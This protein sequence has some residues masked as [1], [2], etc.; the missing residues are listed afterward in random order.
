MKKGLFGRKFIAMMLG[1]LLITAMFV[2]AAT[3]SDT[4]LAPNVVIVYFIMVVTLV[5]MY[6]GGTVWK[7]WIKSKYFVQ[8]LHDE[9]NSQ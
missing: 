4:A 8:A 6:V 7:D 2:V 5:M 3:Q 9:E 1:L